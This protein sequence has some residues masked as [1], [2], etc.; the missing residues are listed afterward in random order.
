MNNTTTAL[1]KYQTFGKRFL[2]SVIDGF[3]FLP[4]AFLINYNFIDQNA[5]AYLI[6]TILYLTLF[7]SY[8]VIGHGKYGQTLGKKLMGVKVL[9]LNEINV[10]GYKR[11]FLRESVWFFAEVI[12]ILFIVYY[13]N[14]DLPREGINSI[15]LGLVTFGSSIWLV[16]EL[17]TMRFN[18]KRRAVHDYIASSVVI[19]QNEM[20]REQIQIKQ[21]ELMQSLK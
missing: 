16:I 3:I 10:I 5:S 18:K 19:N 4:F 2:S 6:Y 11:A 20:R 1:N 12:R 13:I 17:V 7:T 14:Y 15:D 9:D 8:V 21:K